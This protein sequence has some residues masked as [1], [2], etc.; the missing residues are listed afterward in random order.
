MIEPFLQGADFLAELDDATSRPERLDI[1]WLGQSGF[2]LQWQGR[3]LLFDPYLSDSLS[4][5]Y[6]E[7]NKPHV[8]MTELV[9]PCH[10][11]MFAFNTGSPSRFERRCKTLGRPYATLRAGERWSGEKGKQP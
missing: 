7:T 4:R 5:K 2:L 10:F 11:E 3:R 1:W 9:I 6:A 8:R